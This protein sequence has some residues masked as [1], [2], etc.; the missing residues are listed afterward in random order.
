VV[1]KIRLVALTS[2]LVAIGLGGLGLAVLPRR[3]DEAR[4]PAPPAAS[5]DGPPARGPRGAAPAPRQK[6]VALGLFA[7]DVSFDYRPL[8]QEIA[9]LG[10][11]HVALVVP[12]YQEHA[13]ST[14]LYLHTR[15]SPALAATAEAIRAAR[16]LGLEVTLFP[17][18]RLAAPRGPG[19]WRG[20]LKPADVDAWFASYAELLGDHAALAQSV[21]ASR[22]VVGSEL[23]SLD[24]D[25]ARWSRLIDQMRALFPGP[26][27]YSANWDHYKEA[28]LLDLVDEAGVVAYF[29]LRE[30]AKDKPS[31][32]DVAALE[33]RWRELR[34]ELEAW[35]GRRK[36]QPF[37]FTEVG[38]RSR[39]GSSATPWDETPGGA[40]DLDEQRR[41][42]EAF[43]RA[44]TGASSIAGF[45]VWN[46]YGFGGAR[47][48]GY[49]PRGK[50]AA[51]EV[52][53]LMREM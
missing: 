13:G 41:A 22:L 20:T 5:P 28:R 32:S 2:G 3:P 31:P 16:R 25:V 48:L 6:G 36:R 4:G 46:W 15:L 21:G 49:T 14:E 1:T 51:D 10:A 44:W 26:L 38:Y 23:G 40:V 12:F 53:L 29:E 18:V 37:V 47:S 30:K 35:L 8:L 45:Y 34:A 17:I 33:R 42:F 43:R 50:P 7:E 52:R 27:V 11:T 24:G 9:E 19:E 39:A